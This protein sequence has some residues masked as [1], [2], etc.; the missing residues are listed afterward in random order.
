M[1]KTWRPRWTEER[2]S[3]LRRLGDFEGQNLI[4]DR[5]SGEGRPEAFADLAREWQDRQNKY[6]PNWEI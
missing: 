6:V 5:Y 3:E 1:P 2:F 4:I